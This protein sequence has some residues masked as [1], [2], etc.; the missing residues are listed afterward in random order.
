M[1]NDIGIIELSGTLKPED[2]RQFLAQAIDANRMGLLIEYI[3]RYSGMLDEGCDPGN[4]MQW[5]YV[6]ILRIDKG[7]EL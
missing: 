3:E 6:D 7:E 4:S 2:Y 5:A 1:T